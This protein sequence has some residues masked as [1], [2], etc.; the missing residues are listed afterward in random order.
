MPALTKQDLRYQYSWKA[1]LG[2]DP[3]KTLMDADR[4]SREE[5]YEVLY[6]VNHLRGASGA[7]LDKRTRLIVEWMI[8]EKLPGNIQGRRKIESWVI[9]NYPSLSSTYPH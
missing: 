9:Q 5:G 6:F 3:N 1:V 8:K 7:D 4:L 2:D